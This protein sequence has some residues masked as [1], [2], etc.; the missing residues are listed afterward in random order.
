MCSP[1][2]C[3]GGPGAGRTEHRSQSTCTSSRRDGHGAGDV[4][5]RCR[6]AQPGRRLRRRASFSSSATS[7]RPHLHT[8]ASGWLYATRRRILGAALLPRTCTLGSIPRAF[9]RRAEDAPG[10]RGVGWASIV[11]EPMELLTLLCGDDH[12][13]WG[14]WKPESGFNF[15]EK[16]SFSFWTPMLASSGDAPGQ[17]GA[18]I[19][20]GDFSDWNWSNFSSIP[21]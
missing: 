18:F 20:G 12:N 2:L 11:A 6:W 8:P 17:K 5:C 10:T 9:S 15:S 1:L 7:S 16:S 3:M 19:L 4:S 13:F 14:P 21:P